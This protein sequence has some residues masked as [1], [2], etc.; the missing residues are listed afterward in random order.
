MRHW[1][2]M[3]IGLTVLTTVRAERRADRGADLV[4]RDTAS[5]QR[6][7]GRDPARP[8]GRRAALTSNGA[9]RYIAKAPTPAGASYI[10]VRATMCD[11]VGNTVHETVTRAYAQR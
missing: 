7:P 10:S 3:S 8:G 11:S 1:N 4:P 6:R 2:R 9:H 5:E